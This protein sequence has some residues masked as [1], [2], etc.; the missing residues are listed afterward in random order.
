MR[1]KTSKR[2][3]CLCCDFSTR[4]TPDFQDKRG[5]EVTSFGLPRGRRLFLLREGQ[6][7]WVGH[8]S[9]LA[10]GRRGSRVVS[11]ASLSSGCDDSGDCDAGP[12]LLL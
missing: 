9:G 12:G 11:L 8:S 3:L 7:H 1:D 4:R 10:G 6:K 5:I 2:D